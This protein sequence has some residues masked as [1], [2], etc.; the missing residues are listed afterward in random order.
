MLFVNDDINPNPNPNLV[1]LIYK[2]ILQTKESNKN[3][4]TAVPYQFCW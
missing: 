4:I 2:N 3:K 1:Q